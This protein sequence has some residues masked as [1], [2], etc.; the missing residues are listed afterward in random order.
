MVIGLFEADG[1]FQKVLGHVEGMIRMH[2]PGVGGG[3]IPFSPFPWAAVVQRRLVFTSGLTRDIAVFDVHATS[4]APVATVQTPSRELA[5]RDAW[6]ELDE[7]LD[8]AD[9]G[10]LLALARSMDRSVGRVP[11]IARMFADDQG[12]LWVK[13][14]EPRSDAMPVRGGRYAT[15]GRWTIIDITGRVVGHITFPPDIAPVA[16][17]GSYLLGIARDSLD[18]ER[19]TVHRILR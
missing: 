17:D 3:P 15:G 10:P 9:P 6:R 11:Q 2:R 1:S 5:L 14:Y 7:V 13:P 16:A 8:R 18:V 19:F 12:H 4:E